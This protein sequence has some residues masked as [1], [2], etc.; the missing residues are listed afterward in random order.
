MIWTGELHEHHLCIEP[1]TG[2]QYDTVKA[3]E[4]A[5]SSLR[6]HNKCP[7]ALSSAAYQL[8]IP[9]TLR[10]NMLDSF[11]MRSVYFLMCT[12]IPF[13][14]YDFKIDSQQKCLIRHFVIYFMLC[15]I[16][17]QPVKVSKLRLSCS[18]I[19]P[20]AALDIDE[21]SSRRHTCAAN[22][23]C[24]NIPG[25]Y[26][27]KC[28][29]GYTGNGTTCSGEA[30]LFTDFATLTSIEILATSKLEKKSLYTLMLACIYLSW[31]DS[32][33]WVYLSWR[34]SR[35]WV[36]L[37]WRDSRSWV[38]LSWRDSRSWVYPSWRDS[39]SWVY[40]IWRDSRSWVYL[41][42][43]DSRSWVY[44]SWRDSRS[45]VYLSWRGSRISIYMSWRASRS[46]IYDWRLAWRS[47]F[48]STMGAY[49][50][51]P[52]STFIGTKNKSLMKSCVL[53]ISLMELEFTTKRKH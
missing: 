45:W 8:S 14:Y 30:F 40:L 31:R 46:C 18:Y 47:V 36:Y 12:A 41:S 38:Y 50:S 52:G 34:D 27:C 43:R 39:R 48:W 9:T 19:L 17:T 24:S 21:C 22:A 16:G 4:R 13:P 3:T 44:L 42:W 7:G 51:Q 53:V 29:A 6:P 25:S 23:S 20:T 5:T 10:V 33:S 49:S 35:S 1:V 37:S 32:R 15:G 26:T 11:F 28:I 2:F